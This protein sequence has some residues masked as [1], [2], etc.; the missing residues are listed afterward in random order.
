MKIIERRFLDV[1]TP[2]CHAGTIAFFNDEP[3]F[4][5]FGGKREGEPDS[6][7]YLQRDGDV[8]VWGD[9]DQIPRW[10]PILFPFR[11]K[12]FIFT[13][14]GIFCDRWQTFVHD[15]TDPEDGFSKRQIVPAG[16]NGPVKTKPLVVYNNPNMNTLI[17]GSSVETIYD[18]T[19]YMEYF[20]YCS[21]TNEL[22]PCGRSEPLTIPKKTYTDIYLRKRNT[23][24]IIQPSLWQDCFGVIHAFFRSSRGVGK[25]YY[26]TGSDGSFRNPG[27]QWSDPKETELPNPNSGVDTVYHDDRLFLV[28]NPDDTMR[29]PLVVAELD[30]N[31][32]VI[33]EMIVT[34]EIDMKEDTYT[35][36]LSY[37]Y[38]VE[39]D[40]QL[41]LVYTY[42][43]SKIEYV[44]IE[45]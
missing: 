30:K 2:T 26:V 13:K 40:G 6:A 20:H 29:Y 32:K 38:M 5:W 14:S 18:W 8:T 25:I 9:M 37:P 28:Y 43:R 23:L 7:I 31:L 41:H 22:L 45:I 33:N 24:G 36:E 21:E 39:H 4:A 35:R 42:G 11:N 15:I 3:V 34:D 1:N 17:M 10:N 44:T 19:S 27:F 16:F 12:L